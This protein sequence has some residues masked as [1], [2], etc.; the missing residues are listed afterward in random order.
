MS[1]QNLNLDRIKHL[2]NELNEKL[3]KKLNKS[4]VFADSQF[5]EW[6]HLTLGLDK[7]LK[8]VDIHNIKK[9]SSFQVNYLNLKNSIS[10]KIT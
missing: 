2:Q 8:S 5:L 9:L 10:N 3:T 7:L 6:F 4:V 1:I